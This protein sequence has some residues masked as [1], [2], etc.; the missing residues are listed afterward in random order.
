MNKKEAL[1]T[2]HSQTT[3]IPFDALDFLMAL[4]Y[5]EEIE[6]KIIFQL[7]NTYDERI[8]ML[9]SNFPNVPLWYA[10]LAEVHH[11]KRMAP[12]VTKL[13]TTADVPDWDLLDEEGLFLVGMLA[14][15]YPELVSYFLDAIEKQVLQKSNAPYLFL[16][17]A[18]YYANNEVHG[19]QLNRLLRHQDTG[20]KT[21]LAVHIAEARLISCK[22][23]VSKL[24]E[25]FKQF[26]TKG[27]NENLIRE[28]LEY[29]MSLFESETNLPG[30]YYHQR[31]YWRKHYQEAAA[32]FADEN[33][34]L[35]NNFSNIG[36][37]DQ[38]P[39]GS[40]KKFKN[41]CLGK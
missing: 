3:G 27:T 29:A 40:G 35:A 11:T 38:C 21:L 36:R 14:E 9:N 28:E 6:S 26:T 23:E 39:C 8:K 25:E 2:L 13:F 18:I 20:W 4:P 30:C 15:K 33:P 31:G 37:N 24:C 41:C 12:A 16:F 19:E 7:D 1:A 10:I 5:D 22:E 32:L 34:M 17:D